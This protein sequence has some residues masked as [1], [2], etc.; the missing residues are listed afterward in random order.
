MITCSRPKCY[1]RALMNYTTQTDDKGGHYII[2]C[3][4]HRDASLLHQWWKFTRSADW[5]PTKPK[6]TMTLVNKSSNGLAASARKLEQ[7]STRRCRSSS[8]SNR[9]S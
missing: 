3:E 1:R 2:E 9:N 5:V 7:S 6:G 4:S 8:T